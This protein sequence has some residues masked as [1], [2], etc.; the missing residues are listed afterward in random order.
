MATDIC[1]WCGKRIRELRKKRGWT[2]L[3][4][5][6]GAHVLSLVGEGELVPGFFGFWIFGDELLQVSG[7]FDLALF[8]VDFHHD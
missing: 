3:G 5:V 4:A 2:A 8:S 7:E 6:N 1:V